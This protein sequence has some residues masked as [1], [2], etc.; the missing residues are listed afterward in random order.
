MHSP[1]LLTDVSVCNLAQVRREHLVLSARLLSLMRK[2]DMLEAR[3][4]GALGL[5]D[6]S[7]PSATAAVS[8]SLNAIEARLAPSAPSMSSRRVARSLRRLTQHM[9]M[10]L[11][12][13]SSTHEQSLLCAH[14]HCEAGSKS[15]VH[16]S[17]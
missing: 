10:T 13:L 17:P 15:C 12:E 11:P 8:R 9:N 6:A 5:Y 4:A 1:P 3:S 16:F 2:I 14:G 7:C